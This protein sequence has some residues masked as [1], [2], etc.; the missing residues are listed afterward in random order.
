MKIRCDAHAEK[1]K[2]EANASAAQESEA[3]EEISYAEHLE[4]AGKVGAKE[5]SANAAT[6][7]KE[8][9][10]SDTDACVNVGLGNNDDEEENSGAS[11][12]N[13]V[14]KARAKQLLVVW[15]KRKMVEEPR[16]MTVLIM[17]APMAWRA[18]KSC[19]AGMTKK[20]AR[21]ERAPRALSSR[22]MTAIYRGVRQGKMTQSL[23]LLAEVS[24]SKSVRVQST[25]RAWATKRVV[26]KTQAMWWMMKARCL[27]H[28]TKH[29]STPTHQPS[30]WVRQTASPLPVV[31]E[32][33]LSPLLLAPLP[34][35]NV[36]GQI[37]LCLQKAVDL[38]FV[39]LLFSPLLFLRLPKV[40]F[41]AKVQTLRLAATLTLLL[42]LRLSEMN[43]SYQVLLV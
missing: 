7:P 5:A 20:K 15:R 13:D 11:D 21:L 39:L 23:C 1:K 37:C 16:Q 4:D 2:K 27:H 8:K 32:A 42:L 6:E 40:A 26:M 22:Q 3:E 29:T 31:L 33:L 25:N 28:Q 41:G 18:T 12:D 43:A 35:L 9:E 34:E 19:Q 24:S 38:L 36:G 17:R 14:E 30:E 10:T